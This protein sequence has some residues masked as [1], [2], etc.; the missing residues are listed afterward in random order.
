MPFYVSVF[1]K[2]AN[3]GYI[4]NTILEAGVLT[5][6]KETKLKRYISDNKVYQN[7]KYIVFRQRI[8]KNYNKVRSGRKGGNKKYENLRKNID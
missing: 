3:K 1:D 6:I 7:E 4:C 2:E 8:D 5:G